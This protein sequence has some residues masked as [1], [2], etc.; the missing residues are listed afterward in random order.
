[1][2]SVRYPHDPG[3][4]FSIGFD[5]DDE[6]I[7][8]H[9]RGL[10]VSALSAAIPGEGEF[11]LYVRSD[12]SV[13]PGIQAHLRQ[14]SDQVTTDIIDL[15]VHR[16]CRHSS[17]S[18]S[19][20]DSIVSPV[21]VRREYGGKWAHILQRGKVKACGF[22][23]YRIEQSRQRIFALSRLHRQSKVRIGGKQQPLERMAGG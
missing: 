4:D 21:I 22:R 7:Q 16:C 20:T 17:Q 18:E 2:A 15:E 9:A 23:D 19:E 1:M 3:C 8:V 13:K 11:D 10:E 14:G 5:V 6:T 12:G